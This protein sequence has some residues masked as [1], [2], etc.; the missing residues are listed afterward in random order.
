MS[1][2]NLEYDFVTRSARTTALIQQLL[3]VVRELEQMHPGRKFPLDGH[4]VGS[5]GE[6]AAEA[7]FAL[8]LAPT[9]TAGYDALTDDDRKVEVK[10]TFGTTSVAIRP[11]SG[12]HRESAL[13]VL[14]LSK[15]PGTDHEVVYNGPLV[16]ALQVAGPTQSNG[17]AVMHLEHLRALNRSV[18][19]EERVPHRQQL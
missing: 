19:D 14:R 5:I 7:L 17:R 9:S 16:K 4:L 13:I 3:N 15:Q 10:A 6:A 11:T 12:K 1:G 2:E 8:T 18:P